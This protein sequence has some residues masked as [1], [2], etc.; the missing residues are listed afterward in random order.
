MAAAAP[1]E[2]WAGK[3]TPRAPGAPPGTRRPRVAAG[4][5]PQRHRAFG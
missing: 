5:L 1:L 4:S 3:V 2:F